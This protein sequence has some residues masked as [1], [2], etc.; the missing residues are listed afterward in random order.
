MKP[1][2][3]SSQTERGGLTGKAPIPTLWATILYSG[4]R[5]IK[6]QLIEYIESAIIVLFAP[7]SLLKS[8]D[9]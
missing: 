1:S 8:A 9:S 7:H 5:N 6:Y 2:S 3:L 4:A